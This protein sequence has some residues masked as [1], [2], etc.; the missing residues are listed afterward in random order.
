MI[1]I[2]HVV[3]D[4]LMRAYLQSTWTK[5]GLGLLLADPFLF[6]IVLGQYRLAVGVTGNADA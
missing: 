4:N 2:L 5:V 6:I 1:P 3:A